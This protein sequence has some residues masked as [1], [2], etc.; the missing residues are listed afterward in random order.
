MRRG[1]NGFRRLYSRGGMGD[2]G[3]GILGM[4][5]SE[6]EPEVFQQGGKK[7]GKDLA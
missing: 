3:G 6:E 1:G 5:L 2:G 7:S 4:F